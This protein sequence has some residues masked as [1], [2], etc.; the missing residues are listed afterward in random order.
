MAGSIDNRT[1]YYIREFLGTLARRVT[2]HHRSN[3][4]NWS[5]LI[6]RWYVPQLITTNLQPS[7]P[8]IPYSPSTFPINQL[9]L[10]HTLNESIRLQTN[11]DFSPSLD[12]VHPS[13]QPVHYPY[14]ANSPNNSKV[15]RWYGMRCRSPAP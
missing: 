4:Y 9:P 14:D 12:E 2:K 1:K 11:S 5:N 15:R 6:R 10:D 3:N 8:S 7:S 13:K